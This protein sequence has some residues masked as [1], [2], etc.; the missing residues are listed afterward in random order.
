MSG[1]GDAPMANLAENLTEAPS[2]RRSGLL[3]FLRDNPTIAICVSVLLAAVA[4]AVF[5]PLLAGDPLELDPINRLKH[6]GAEYW[7]GTDRIGRDIFA[8]TV[9]GTRVSLLVGASVT[10]LAISVG[11]TIGLL[12][13]YIRVVDAVA[14]RFMD[15]LMAIPGILL[16]IAMMTLFGSSIP[17]VIIAISIPEIPGVV[18][19][20]RSVVL[21]L[22]EQPYVEAAV[23]VGTRLP[24][25]LIRHIL[26]NTIAPLLV[27]GSLVFAGAVI[28]EAILSFLGAG[29]PPETP[30]WG[31]MVAEGRLSF[32]I[33]PWTVFFPG[34]C[35]ALVVLVINILGDSLRDTLDPRIA[36]TV[37]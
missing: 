12:A 15:A 19:L 30:S 4:V 22:R 6:P 27:Q 29:T 3:S 33:A 13:G 21:S 7:F 2:E 24:K 37:G 28:S 23:A 20:V 5:A 1:A 26:P 9:Y 16:A 25:I 11:L 32:Q 34:F 14:M 10:V 35:L 31:N 18:R 36:K 8:R 17:N